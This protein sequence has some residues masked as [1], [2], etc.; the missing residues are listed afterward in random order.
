MTYGLCIR[1]DEY[2]FV[3]YN[4]FLVQLISEVEGFCLDI[5]HPSLTQSLTDGV[6]FDDVLLASQG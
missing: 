6:K 4:N 3:Y 5:D 2:A 1:H